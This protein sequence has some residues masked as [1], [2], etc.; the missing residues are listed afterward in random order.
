MSDTGYRAFYHFF[1]LL[2]LTYLV[3]SQVDS[4]LFFVFSFFSL[5]QRP[6][7]YFAYF[8][9]ILQT[10]H[11]KNKENCLRI[12]SSSDFKKM[13]WLSDFP[14]SSDFQLK[15]MLHSAIFLHFCCIFFCNHGNNHWR[16]NGGYVIFKYFCV[17]IELAVCCL[18]S[19]NDRTPRGFWK[20]NV[21][22]TCVDVT[23]GTNKIIGILNIFLEAQTD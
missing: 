23:N 19:F 17:N 4:G 20:K 13:W 15:I 2:C 12:L 3:Y 21:K 16:T 6:S 1:F 10:R 5:L 9:G 11:L 14:R 18:Q 7:C 22:T 8:N